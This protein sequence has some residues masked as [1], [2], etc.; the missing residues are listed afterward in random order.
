LQQAGTP[1]A[2]AEWR[3]NPATGCVEPVQLAPAPAARFAAPV[4]AIQP[5]ATYLITGGL[6]ALGLATARWLAQ[7]GARQLVLV[8]RRAPGDAQ[9]AAI[10][11]LE[12]MGCRVAVERLDLSEAAAV[13]GLLQRI[14]A[15]GRALH[16]I[17][18][19]AGVLDDGLLSNQTPE[20]CAAVAAA[21]L[22]GA[23]NL[24]AASR[25]LAPALEFFVCYSSVAALLGSPGQAAYAAAN[26]AL[27]GLMAARRRAGLPG[28]SLNW[29]PWAGE[30]MASRAPQLLTPIQPD[31]ALASLG[32]WLASGAAQGV[33]VNLQ[34]ASEHRLAPRC[35]ALL[36]ELEVLPKAAAGDQ[37][38]AR[39]AA[40]QACLAD[41]LADLGGFEAAELK[42]ETS[43]YGL[44]L[45]S[46]MAVELA[47][48]VQAG[49]GVSLGLG[50]LAGEPTLA[51]LAAHVLALLGDP[52][53]ASD[54]GVDLRAEAQLPA[55]LTAVFAALAQPGPGGSG[56]AAADHQVPATILLTGATGF[57]GAF[58]LADQL[59]RH[60]QLQVWC[61][62]R[63]D[64]PGAAK[65][66]V[67][68]NLQHYGL[69][70]PNF[71][72]RLVGLPGD[73]ALPQ[74]GLDDATWAGLAAGIGGILH[75]GAQLSYVAPY[76]QLRAA[77]VGGTLAVLQLA[78]AAGAPVEFIS[79]T[80]V[81]EAAAYRGQTIA[82]TDDVDAWQGIHLGYSQTKWVSERLVLAAA[83]AGWP[84]SVYRPPLIGGHSQS[85]AWHQDDFLHRLVRGC[86]ALGQA[87]DL[88]MELDLVPVDYVVAAIG[89]LAWRPEPLGFH[90][91]LHHPKPVLWADLLHGLIDKGAPLQAVPLPQWL[92]ALAQQPSNP[93]Y[94]LQ[95]FFTHRWGAE[96]LTYPEL[97]APGIKARPSCDRS[98]ALLEPLGVRCPGFDDLI[99]PYA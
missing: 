65:A 84:V 50:A 80:S 23:L 12:A 11:A 41:L 38:P 68:A 35:R 30:G 27:D 57:L 13:R 81:Y 15:D 63:A 1:P 62:V 79:S 56:P 34:Q 10:A 82:E 85:G 22:G 53:A 71:G 6:G 95:P 70:D 31:A 78:A 64:G 16:G 48:A 24:E 36:A 59:R 93:L 32:R 39:L 58:L 83:A 42:P 94:P 25:D 37:E 61:L 73:L 74:L 54:A 8:G 99:G 17:V 21:K 14:A 55:E 46:L 26:G 86:L 33:V 49:L 18:H 28:L 87:P 60:P 96:Q 20:R 89:A 2:G 19:A 67:Q 4:P 51:A 9:Q 5:V 44:G 72:A 45:D 88:A 75:N 7:R 76:S 90:V 3:W 97:N 29:G 92:A 40:V 66:R 91:H 77:N 52:A 69:W 98:R 43:L 47:T